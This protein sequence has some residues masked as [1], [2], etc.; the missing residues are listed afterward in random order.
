MKI[1]SILGTVFVFY[2]LMMVGVN[3]SASA[4]IVWIEQTGPFGSLNAVEAVDADTAW[5]VGQSG[6]I[7][8]T[9]DGGATWVGQASGTGNSLFGISA[10]DTSTAY[11]VGPSGTILKTTDGGST[12]ITQ[13]S[14]GSGPST[15]CI[16]DHLNDVSVVDAS[17]AWAVGALG[18][19]LY[20]T[21]GG[22]TWTS[23]TNPVSGSTGIGRVSAV[24]ANT[25]WAAIFSGGIK[26]IYTDN[27][28]T[29][30]V[31][32]TPSPAEPVWDVSAVDANTAWLVGNTGVIRYTTNAGGTWTL[33]TSG[34]TNG[35]TGVSAVDANTAWAVGSSDT[36]LYTTDAGATWSAQTAAVSGTTTDVSAANAGNAWA[37]GFS[38][39][40][41]KADDGTLLANVSIQGVCEIDLASGS[42]SFVTGDPISNGVDVGTGEISE[43][44]SNSLGNLGSMVGVFGTDWTDGGALT[45][46]LAGNT[47]VS[48]VSDPD[49]TTKTALT[50]T[51]GTQV[52]LGTIAPQTDITSYWDVQIVMAALGYSGPAVQTITVDFTCV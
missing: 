36:I 30:W 11:A 40:I 52:P 16:S 14:G 7:Q 19:L 20:T 3:Q 1:K 34:T 44:M 17:T 32:Q 46:M 2:L 22:T 18:A 25:A 27:G 38:S 13:C 24:D 35:L 23:Q 6:A 41:Q 12:W 42:L 21:D 31:D 28:G 15:G 4:A 5:A 47:K 8:K 51:Q 39:A 26:L 45:V 43:L 10:V 37:V 33:Q 49:I 48:T 9:T 50:T 29:T